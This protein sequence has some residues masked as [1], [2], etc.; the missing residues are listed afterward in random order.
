MSSPITG[1]GGGIGI[2]LGYVLSGLAYLSV[3]RMTG[4][5]F[6]F[7]FHPLPPLFTLAFCLLIGLT[8][9]LYP[10]WRASRI[11]PIDALR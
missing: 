4:T 5:S 10:A 8:F 6:P 1:T 3:V 9:G 7:P 2:L 11:S